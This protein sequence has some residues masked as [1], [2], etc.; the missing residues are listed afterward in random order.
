MTQSLGIEMS[1]RIHGKA[2]TFVRVF[3]VP[4]MA[5]CGGGPATDDFDAFTALRA[6]VERDQAPER[7]VARAGARTPWPGRSRPLCAY[8]KV[9]RYKGVGNPESADSFT[10]RE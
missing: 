9:A 8:P 10:C 5:H 4:G 6:W 7:I 1:M 3:P 2:D